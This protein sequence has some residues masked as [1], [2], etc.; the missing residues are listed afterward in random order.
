MISPPVWRGAASSEEVSREHVHPPVC[1]GSHFLCLL[2]Q[3]PFEKCRKTLLFL[4]PAYVREASSPSLGS[5]ER[6]CLTLPLQQGALLHVTSTDVNKCTSFTGPVIKLFPVITT[7]RFGA[8]RPPVPLASRVHPS[9]P[10]WL[11]L[12]PWVAVVADGL[13]LIMLIFD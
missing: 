11:H 2:L 7:L 3:D 4:L 12:K 10:S 6:V 5:R 8:G 1:R 9:A 13:L